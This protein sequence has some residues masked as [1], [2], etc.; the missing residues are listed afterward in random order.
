MSETRFVTC[1]LCEAMCGLHMEVEGDR[2]TSVRG[3][4]ADVFSRG[5]ICPKGYALRELAADPDRL[6]TPLRRTRSG[7]EAIGWNDA[8]LSQSPY[9]I[10]D[11]QEMKTVWHP[12]GF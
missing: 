2:I 12:I 7:W 5:H 11:F 10:F 8:R 1:N 4:P 6:R 9:A 3:N